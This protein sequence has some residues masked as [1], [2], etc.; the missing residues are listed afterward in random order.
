M[1][2]SRYRELT[3]DFPPGLRLG[4]KTD[5][6]LGQGT[7][8][9]GNAQHNGAL[10]DGQHLYFDRK[11]SATLGFHRFDFFR[12]KRLLRWSGGRRA[13]P[14]FV[15]PATLCNAL[16]RVHGVPAFALSGSAATTAWSFAV[17]SGS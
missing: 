12:L 13:L 15:R 16:L 2:G 14:A 4:D 1:R 11:M 10:G 8:P 3:R 7:A 9:N 6:A 17:S 5:H